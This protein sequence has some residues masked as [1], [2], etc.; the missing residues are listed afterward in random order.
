MPMNADDRELIAA[1]EKRLEVWKQ[2]SDLKDSMLTTSLVIAMAKGF[3]DDGQIRTQMMIIPNGSS[4]EMLGLMAGAEV[5][6][7]LDIEEWLKEG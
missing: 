7:K 2:E 3:D 1:I 5:R 4:E 6:L